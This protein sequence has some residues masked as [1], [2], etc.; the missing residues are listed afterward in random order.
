MT[1]SKSDNET[2][3]PEDG[4]F[5]DR[6]SRRK[7]VA[8]ESQ[9]YQKNEI[10]ITDTNKTVLLTDAD[11]P[12]IESLSEDSDYTGFLSPKVSESLRKQA[13][14][15]LFV[16]PGFNVR[17]GLDD[18]DGDYTEFEKLGDIV[19]A[20]MRHQMEMKSRRHLE[21]LVEQEAA[22]TDEQIDIAASPEITETVD[23]VQVLDDGDTEQAIA[24]VDDEKV[25][26]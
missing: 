24:Q 7:H 23:D 2:I 13:L 16:S 18:Y 25:E 5:I 20:D 26:L 6:W 1:I 14:R 3:L 21:Q 19:T 17:D 10:S 12:P 15:R 4:G 8:Q 9:T 11:M 22:E